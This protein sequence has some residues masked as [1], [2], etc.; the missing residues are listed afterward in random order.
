MRRLRVTVCLL[1]LGLTGCKG[2]FGEHELPDDPLFI[3]R[4]PVEAKSEQTAPV[5]VAHAEPTP[6]ANPYYGEPRSPLI[7]GTLRKGRSVPGT[8]TSRPAPGE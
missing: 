7:A 4:K 3:S 6:P 2:L 1:I 5:P 8:P